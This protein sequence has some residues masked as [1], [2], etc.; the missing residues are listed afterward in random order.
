MSKNNPPQKR[1]LIIEDE[2]LLAKALEIKLNNANFKTKTV[3][4]GMTGLKVLQTEKFDLVI[5][6]LLLPKLDGFDMLRE[7]KNQKD[8]DTPV[9]VSSNLSQINERV[10]AK[11]L[12]VV[13]YFIKS[14]TPIADIV[15]CINRNLTKNHEN[16]STA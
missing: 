4:D 1:I 12:G 8:F 5:L 3:F 6:D 11:K 2:R 13:D 15:K 7:L 9:I 14:N 16:R 10:E